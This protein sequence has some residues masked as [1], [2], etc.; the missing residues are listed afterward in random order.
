MTNTL[1][2]ISNLLSN[3]ASVPKDRQSIFFKSG[4]GDYAEHD[5]F[6]GVT[7]PMLRQIAKK[8]PNLT[9]TELQALLESS[10]NEQRFLAL[11]IL[12]NQYNKAEQEGKEAIY[13]FYLTNLKHIN[14]WNLVDA[15]A[16]LIIG[17]HLFD[18]NKDL[19]FRLAQSENLWERRISI[20]SSWYFIKNNDLKWTFEIAEK[21][22]NDNH[23][24]IHKAV[25]WM[26][27]EAGKKDEAALIEFLD[28]YS[29]IMPRTMLRYSLEKFSEPQRKY[30]LSKKTANQAR[31][32][33]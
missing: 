12:V 16:H 11:I 19:L 20:V 7:V 25:G 22:L 8:Y 15:S 26:L 23:D 17:A 33:V 30:Y 32:N 10:I 21:L 1:S 2:E 4:P 31:L 9:P 6:I 14:N 13:Q 18:K 28:S 3:S 27:R 29:Q 24:L 5:V